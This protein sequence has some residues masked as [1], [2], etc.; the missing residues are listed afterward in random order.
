MKNILF[1]TITLLFVSLSFSNVNAQTASTDEASILKM[2]DAVWN[3]YESGDE[4]KMWSFYAENACEVYPDG[5]SISGIKAI[6][7]GY[8][9]FKTMLEGKPSWSMTKPAI[10]FFGSDL[11]LL[12]S[13]VTADIKLKG[14]QQ[15]GG[16]AKFATIAHRSNGNWLIVFDSQ[17]PVMEMPATN[18]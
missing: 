1:S 10:T 15:I 12:V 3:A 9:Q 8:E 7:E 13:D 11:V 18:K 2:W 6:R 4:A 16:K 14:G 17:T 5:S